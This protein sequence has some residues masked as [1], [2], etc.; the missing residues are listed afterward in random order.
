MMRH[1]TVAAVFTFTSLLY[2]LLS[3][4]TPS[5]KRDRKSPKTKKKKKETSHQLRRSRGCRCRLRSGC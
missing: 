2:I 3:N 4:N 1:K 5:Y